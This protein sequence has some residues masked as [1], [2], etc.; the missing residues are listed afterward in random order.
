MPQLIRTHNV[1]VEG[2]PGVTE[3]RIVLD[4]NITVKADGSLDVQTKARQAAAPEEV[5]PEGKAGE[6][7]WAI[8]TFKGGQKIN[9][10]KKEE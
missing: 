9:F 10:G 4:L 2:E 1:H 6:T 8:P 5:V 3:V 7:A